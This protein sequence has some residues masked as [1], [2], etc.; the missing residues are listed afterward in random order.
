M[1]IT[2]HL[3]TCVAEEGAEIAQ[4]ADKSLRFGLL[5]V[6]FLIPNGPNNTE[7]L[8]NELN[9]LLGVVDMLVKR[10]VIPANWQSTMKQLKKKNKVIAM[11]RYAKRVGTLQCTKAELSKL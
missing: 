1:N 9:D 4:D 2:E 6:N 3:L 10:G 11:M 5:D 7:R 8:V